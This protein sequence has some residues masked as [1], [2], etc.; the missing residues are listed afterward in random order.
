MTDNTR[1]ADYG[2]ITKNQRNTWATGDFNQIARQNVGMAEALCETVD[3]HPGERVLDVGCGS[4]TAALV[5]ER[6]YCDV[7]GLDYVPEL[8]ERA[9]TRAQAN[10]QTI[11][12]RVG[13]AQDMP[14]PDNSFDVILSVYG[15]QFAPNQEQAARELLRVCKPGGKI[16]LAGP[17]PVGWSGDW[18]G[19]HAEYMP[20]PPHVES[21]LRWG[22]AE[23]LQELFGASVRSIENER[24]TALQYYRSIDHAVEVFSTYFGPTVRA[25]ETIDTAHQENLLDDLA[26]V[27]NRYNQAMDGTAIV[28]NQYLQTIVTNQ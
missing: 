16:S 15:V 13:D 17:I 12:F 21:P 25:L 18:F 3:P 10:G 11:D 22:T 24:R 5:A 6:R 14:F 19:V 26:A 7:T 2:E 23:G 9:E 28:E 4:G 8:I 27:M 1:T 20:P